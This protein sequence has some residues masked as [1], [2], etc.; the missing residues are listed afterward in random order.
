MPYLG[1]C[2]IGWS[3]C[4]LCVRVRS[5]M[6]AVEG[7][8][9]GGRSS[10]VFLAG[11]VVAATVLG[12]FALSRLSVDDTRA[13][14]GGELIVY[15][16]APSAFGTLLVPNV[17]ADAPVVVLVHGGFWRRRGGDTSLMESLADDL[18]SRGVAVWN[19]EYGRSG[20]RL[21][22]YPHTFTHVQDAVDHLAVLA[23]DRP[24][25]LE[26][27]S[28]VGHSA[29]G[30]LALWLGGRSSFP[31]RSAWD[32][33]VPVVDPVV[34]IRS[35]V[36]L[37]PIV[38]LS[39]AADSLLGNG[40]VVDLLGG[41]PADVPL[42]YVVATPVAVGVPTLVITGGADDDVPSVF[43]QMSSD[44]VNVQ[45][46]RIDAASHF[47]LIDPSAAAWAAVLQWL[48]QQGSL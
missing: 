12:V 20:E 15:G 29:G 44:S 25:D 10:A 43:S 7:P 5:G 13:A 34:D 31:A 17:A 47:D 45:T 9:A 38:D 18:V 48:E 39:A 26:R 21:G 32:P 27:V 40:A 36:G 6:R 24:L 1:K 2:L 35:V 30:Q 4:S 28:V 22:G 46:S 16:E 42:R 41:S 3:E 14:G 33:L 23:V 8:D 37:A 19:I 11:L